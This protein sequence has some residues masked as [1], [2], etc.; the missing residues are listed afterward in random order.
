MYKLIVE[1]TQKYN[2][3]ENKISEMHKWNTQ[4]KR[5]FDVF[6]WLAKNANPDCAFDELVDAITVSPEDIVFMF[7]NSV[8]DTMSLVFSRTIYGQAAKPLFAFTHKLG[9][10]YIYNKDKTWTEIPKDKLVRFL[11]IVQ[12]KL[13]K[14]L[15]L[16]KKCHQ[17][18]INASDGISI[19]YVE[20]NLLGI[21]INLYSAHLQ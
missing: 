9:I 10:L 20:K 2:R 8:Y 7:N 6:E 14:A 13:S 5:K 16:W 12:L 3:L 11:N 4:Q 17:E 19:T 18:E 1:L 21:W 15:T